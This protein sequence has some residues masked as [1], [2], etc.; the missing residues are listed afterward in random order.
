MP[1]FQ[2]NGPEANRLK[3]RLSEI[4]GDSPN[5]TYTAGQKDPHRQPATQPNVPDWSETSGRGARI[6]LI[7]DDRLLSDTLLRMLEIAGFSVFATGLGQDALDL[8]RTYRFDLVLLDLSLPDMAGQLVLQKIHALRPETPIIILSGETDINVKVEGFME[9]ADDYVT[10]PFHRDELLARIH[11]ILR[12][13]RSASLADMTMGP[14]TLDF[15]V[16][17]AT[18]NGQRIPLTGKEY[19]C[20]ELL[21]QRRGT[22]VTKDMFL[23]HLYGGRGEPEMKIIDVFICKIRRKLADAGVPPLIETVWGRGYTI[24]LDIDEE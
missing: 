2:Q 9:G 11:A 22:T 3:L 19:A 4:R 5:E 7:E 1:S 16:H 21:A 18:A 14:L 6:L 23:A 13:A 8:F 12:R 10:K 24:P 20:L 17:R 15:S